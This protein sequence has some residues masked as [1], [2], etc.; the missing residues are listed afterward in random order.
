MADVVLPGI[1]WLHGTRGSNVFLVEAD[2]GSLAL[3]DTG[4]GASAGEILRQIAEVAPGRRLAAILLT[5][6]HADHAGS[7]G[8]LHRATGAPVVL[9]RGDCE[10]RDRELTVRPMAG[11]THIARFILRRFHGAGGPAT[12]VARPIESETEVL[13]G[14]LA[15]P[16]PGHTRGSCV[17][18]VPRLDAAFAG[19]LIISHHGALARSMRMA[20][21]DDA[22]YL[23]TLR[24]YAARAPRNGLPGH[25]TPVLGT[26]GDALRVLAALPRRGPQPGLFGERARRMLSFMRTL[27]SRREP[28]GR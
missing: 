24:A 3:V 1:W 23:A 16:V 8:A 27:L 21:R 19:D 28:A 6:Y 26:F 9:G 20:N 12:P 14:I 15:V 7:A 22:Q 13:P 10:E 5:H 18:E 4:F 2:D 17:F 25:G 11:R